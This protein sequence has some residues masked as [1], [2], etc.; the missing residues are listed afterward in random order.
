M[1]RSGLSIATALVA[2]LV[3]LVTLLLTAFAAVYYQS[4]RD[5]R[6]GE[7]GV[8]LGISADQQAAALQLPLW[9]LDTPQVLSILRSGMR[10]REVLALA[11]LS[12]RDPL[13]MARDGDGAVRAMGTEPAAE[14]LL[15]VERQIEFRGETLGQL[16]L[17]GTRAHLDAGL[18]ALRGQVFAFILLLDG[19]L[20]LCLYL[21]LWHLLL[22]PLQAVHRYAAGV[23]ANAH[24]D[25]D[26]PNT[27]FIG[28][29]A[30]LKASL[31]DMSAML[32]ARFRA[33]QDSEER[34][35]LATRA[36][37]IGIWDWDVARNALDWDEQMYRL[38]G[39][40]RQDFA[41]DYAAWTSALVPDQ[42]RAAEAEVQA[43]LRGERD[44]VAEF[45]VQRPDGS[46]RRI[47]GEAVIVRDDAGQA[48]RMV[49]VNFDITD[50]HRAEAE[51]RSL[52]AELEDRVS[53][54]TRQLEAVVTELAQAR[55]EAES[56]TRAKSEFLANMSH[57]IRT[58]MNAIIGMTELAMR[59]EPTPRQQGY[60]S[61]ARS[62][63][64]SLLVILNDIL[65]F[66]KI[67]AGKLDLE[68]REFALQGVL[69]RVTAII[70]L[71][72][73]EKG[74]ELLLSTAADV[75]QQLVGDSV[76][77]EQVLINLCGNAVKFTAQGE[78]VVVT[79]KSMLTDDNRVMLR[80]SVRDT[81][82]GMDEAQAARLFLPFNQLDASTTRRYGGTGLGLAISKQLVELM[83][84]TI[85]VRSQPGK[86]SDFHF[87]ATFGRSATADDGVRLSDAAL[88]ELRILVVDDSA[89]SRAIFDDLLRGLGYRPA[90][91]SS[92]AEGLDELRRAAPHQPYD[93][94]LL[95]WR[96]P[97]VDGFEF[98]QRL[99]QTPPPGGVPRLIM[100]TAFGDEALVRRAHD[101]GMDGCLAKPVSASTLVDAIA[102]AFGGG[103]GV[104]SRTAADGAR[105]GAPALLRGREVLL[106]EDNEF[107]QIVAAELL[108]DVGG[109][110]VSLAVNGQQALAMLEGQ[111]FDAVLMDVQMPVMDGYQ[112]TTLIRQDPRFQ[113]LPIIAMTAHAM[114]RDREKCLAVGMDDHI[115][116]P[117]D[118]A[119]L[120][121][122]LARWI[123][124]HRPQRRQ[125][126]ADG[127]A[128][129][130]AQGVSFE[131]GLQRCMGRADL[132]D[133]VLERYLQTQADSIASVRAALAA[134]D[135]DGIG[136]IAH[137]LITSA[138]TIG[139]QALAG[140]AAELQRCVR[141]GE[142]ARLAALV[143]SLVWH[144]EA[145][146]R[147]L[148]LRLAAA[149]GRGGGGA[150][151]P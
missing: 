133:K 12:A 145:V 128:P 52:N 68:V 78:I 112:A 3:A 151:A 49:G 108:T 10:E 148:R 66:S 94:V 103:A 150:A 41:G 127:G 130:R 55:D 113:A 53:E 32:D 125:S 123:G 42:R 95:D 64:E 144:H 124:A 25:A 63:A 134:G 85:G 149:P 74:L 34:L 50:R 51:I 8:S 77:L 109:M 57:E 22:K 90:L 62:A 37:N 135:V 146:L 143:D 38:Y 87:T 16:R 70:G 119:E 111:R 13:V 131:L 2:A 69:D 102:T 72:A 61:K 107:N 24:G 83:G 92:A 98:A 27:L 110:R 97:Q 105:P 86:G 104:A 116:K 79:V 4:E 36:L 138:G 44:F 93:L 129:L 67:E 132:Y 82:V 139:A 6:L 81:G 75:P 122:T 96:M 80:F 141:A 99:R 48:Q 101:E 65:D 106:V 47:R 88:R 46:L 59:S 142:T 39:L 120:F 20:V 15:M 5:R 126:A 100:I 136:G 117:F 18:A 33:L 54:R 28:E 29:L 35:K 23:G 76:R 91:A 56:A 43:A 140:V 89:N 60:L 118:P 17:Y 58:P 121:A 19:V 7:L 21:L 26:A 40:R 14:G 84:G 9:N 115:A 71:K 11:V 45:N 30:S 1:K 31:H 137:T 114:A 147:D 73:N